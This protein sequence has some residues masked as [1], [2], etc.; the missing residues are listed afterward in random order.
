L[1]LFYFIYWRY[2][3]YKRRNIIIGTNK[4]T[5]VDLAE[6]VLSDTEDE[7]D[8]IRIKHGITHVIIYI[9]GEFLT[10]DFALSLCN[11]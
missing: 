10:L 1:A 3:N 5:Q 4:E 6:H 7:S 2:I 11:F 8:L 9:I